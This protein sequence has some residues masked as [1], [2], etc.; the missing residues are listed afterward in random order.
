MTEQT[1]FNCLQCK[2]P[3][4][5]ELTRLGIHTL[6]RRCRWLNANLRRKRHG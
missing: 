4:R 2:R 5:A 3:M 1:G 6:C